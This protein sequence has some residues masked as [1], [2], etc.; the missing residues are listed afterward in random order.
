[1]RGALILDFL[2]KYIDP[3]NPVEKIENIKIRSSTAKQTL[4]RINWFVYRCYK[5]NVY[6][7]N[8]P[9]P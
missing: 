6:I 9:R 1:M 3:S 5:D 7:T 2:Y 8:E 4:D